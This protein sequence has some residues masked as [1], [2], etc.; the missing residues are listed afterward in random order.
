MAVHQF[1]SVPVDT[2]RLAKFQHP[3][4]V[5]PKAT[6]TMKQGVER[7]V[8]GIPVALRVMLARRRG[9]GYGSVRKGSTVYLVSRDSTLAQAIAG[10]FLFG[11]SNNLTINQQRSRRTHNDQRGL[12]S[13][14]YKTARIIAQAPRESAAAIRAMQQNNEVVVGDRAVNPT[15]APNSA[16]QACQVVPSA[17]SACQNIYY[18]IELV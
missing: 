9:E 16:L 15:I 3:R 14:R 4:T 18:N 11:S 6:V 10:G 7:S 2:E 12:N 5:A 13:E 8:Q 1:V 17:S